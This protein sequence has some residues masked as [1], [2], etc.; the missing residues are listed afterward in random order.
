MNGDVVSLES[1]RSRVSAD[2]VQP[3]G[4]AA[5]GDDLV[6]SLLNFAQKWTYH[7][8]AMRRKLMAECD[9]NR[10]DLSPVEKEHAQ[11]TLNLTT[12]DTAR[13]SEMLLAAADDLAHEITK[14][15]K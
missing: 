15:R 8:E 14:G 3:Q 11:A 12:Q 13:T 9:I 1:R 5:Q 4:L 7:T 10:P 6:K 2:A